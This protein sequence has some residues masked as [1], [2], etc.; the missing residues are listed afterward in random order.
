MSTTYGLWTIVNEE[1]IYKNDK[2]YLLCRCQC[3]IEKEV[4][5]KNLKSGQSTSCGCV[6]R[7]NLSKR[8]TKH[9]LR[10]TKT[11]RA[12]QAM[13]NRCYNKS[14]V[15]YPNYGGRG[16]T[17]CDEWKNDF[18]AFYD[19]VGEAPPDKTLD[20]IDVNGNYEPGN[21]KWSSSK[22]QGQNKRNNTKVDGVCISDASRALG[23]NHSLINKRLKR[24]WSLER[25]TTEKS[26]AKT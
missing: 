14:V 10:F 1:K 26:H 13:K 12:W 3:G 17:V 7:A 9:G 23:G 4:I 15:A 24:G 5:V 19:Y 22:E 16:I 18:N 25:A 8:N 2:V 6:R 20:R 21:V 11:W